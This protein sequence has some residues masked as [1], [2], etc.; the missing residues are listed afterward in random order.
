[1]DG[2]QYTDQQRAAIAKRGVSIALSAGA[3]C[4]KTM[5]LTERF[6]SHL[7]PRGAELA[8][9]VAITFTERAAREMRSRIR[10]RCQE[11]L[12]AASS[13][14]EADHWQN[15]ARELESARISTI[16]AFCAG[17]LRAHA[18]EAGLDPQFRVLD[19]TQTQ[20]LLAEVIDDALRR[21]LAEQR[22]AVMDLIVAYGLLTTKN[23]VRALLAQRDKI[24]FPAW[25]ERTADD[26]LRLWTEFHR[27]VIVPQ[28]LRDVAQGEA[29]TRLLA[30][31]PNNAPSHPAMQE[32]REFLL[33][34]LP[35]LA[36]SQDPRADLGQLK[37]HARVQGGGGKGAWADEETYNAV[38]DA[39]A[40]LRGDI[41]SALQMIDFQVQ[42]ARPAAVAGLQLLEITQAAADT[43]VRRKQELG[44][45]DFDDLLI[46]TRGL[47]RNP[48]HDELRRQLGRQIHALLVDEFQDTDP[49]QVDLVKALC[50]DDL[51]KGKLF[52]VGD[53]KQSIYRFRRADARVFR[54]LQQETPSAGRLPLTLNFR[55]QPQILAFVN[56]LFCDE[57]GPDYEPLRAHRSQITPLPVVEFLWAPAENPDEDTP[58]LRRREAV[59]IARRLRALLDDQASGGRQ[60]PDGRR[61]HAVTDQ[62]ADAPRSPPGGRPGDIAI[63]FRALSD[64]QFYE[65]ALRQYGIDFYLV[66]GHAFYAQQEI[67][68]LLNLLRTLAYPADP[69]SLAGVLRSPFFSLADETLYWLA[70]H[71]GGLTAGLFA[72]RL[73]EELDDAQRRRVEFAAATITELRAR[74]DRVH[75]AALVE[76]AM[77]RTGY[78]AVLLAEFMGQRKLANL[79]KLIQQARALDRTGIFTLADF[80]TQLSEFVAN[81]PDEPLAATMP[82]STDVVK[83]MTV[84]QA[85]GLEFPLVVVPD[86]QR[87]LNSFVPPAAFHGDLGPLVRSAEFDRRE[88]EITGHD[89]LK[90]LEANEDKAEA[91]RLFYVATTRAADYLMLSSGVSKLGQASGPWMSLLAKRFDLFTGELCCQLPPGYEVP[92]VRVISSE[93]PLKA[94]R[95]QAKRPTLEKIVAEAN[96]LIAQGVLERPAT[97]APVPV[98]V[99]ARR[100]F[101]FSRLSGMLQPVKPAAAEDPAAEEV[102][103]NQQVSAIDPLGLG[104]LLHA[105]MEELPLAE[106]ERLAA[107]DIEQLVQRHAAI[108]LPNDME[109]AKVTLD[110]VTRFLRSPLA[111]ELAAAKELHREV[112]FLLAWPPDSPKSSGIYLRGYI[113]CL[114]QDAGDAW[115]LVDYKTN[116]TTKSTLQ[117]IASRYEMQML[118]YGLAAEAALGQRVES[119]ALYFLRAGAAYTFQLDESARRRAVT[120][121]NQAI[122]RYLRQAETDTGAPPP[123]THGSNSVSRAVPRGHFGQ[124]HQR[125]LPGF[126]QGGGD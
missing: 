23:M 15:I 32:R 86:L 54:Q 115:R 5:V 67:F 72:P 69:V 9:L 105:V 77:Q 57:L 55:S 18:V 104:T 88:K 33:A 60:P 89:F 73:P 4:G 120:L 106:H 78:D 108:H 98:D 53:Y 71:P 46:R 52:F 35:R 29:A 37:E 80:I 22:P 65:D 19:A 59:W 36:D 34:H 119:L 92:R 82:E 87:P 28:T 110:M 25:R 101:S 20:T 63:L 107:A 85:K 109:G 17:L 83:L 91:L 2:T 100:E 70:K 3:G 103:V 68:D 79:R 122:A 42:S 90:R 11:R 74:K 39:A 26:V 124:P 102:E 50:G 7:E 111:A 81:Q 40:D 41:E 58:S 113:D 121:V 45:L 93:P 31:L 96:E 47:L 125:Q 24:D 117:D 12:L 10:R 49:L 95:G 62:G 97:I 116:V 76:E 56:A 99:A 126:S 13:P 6:L 84:H 61:T 112:E 16:H 94:G 64:V 27:A 75:I 8:D 51:Q 123:A 118:V 14:E 43:Y 114:Y 66:G 48:R 38:R 21:L 1:V 44:V 30:V